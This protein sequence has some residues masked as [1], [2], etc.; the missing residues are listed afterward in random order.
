M[1]SYEYALLIIICLTIP[2]ILYIRIA[3]SFW[4]HQ[5]ICHTYDFIRPWSLPREGILLETAPTK[6]KFCD[7]Y[8]VKTR[9]YHDIT[10]L[11]KQTLVH[12][13]QANYI[14]SES[15]LHMISATTL[16]Q[17]MT[18]FMQSPAV[19]IYFD[20]DYTAAALSRDPAKDPLEQALEALQQ[21]RRTPRIQG[22]MLS[23]QIIL[24]DPAA[25]SRQTPLYYWNYICTKRT[26]AE[27]NKQTQQLIQTHDY[28]IRL[29]DN[30]GTL[31]KKEI[32]LCQGVVPLVQYRSYSYIIAPRFQLRPLSPFITIHQL[33]KSEIGTIITCLTTSKKRY[34]L[35]EIGNICAL[36]DN[37][38][39][40]V[41]SLKYR[42]EIYGMYFVKNANMHYDGIE[43]GDIGAHAGNA[44]QLVAS[45]K[46]VYSDELFVLG[47]EHVLHALLKIR[48]TYRVLLV[49][50]MA[51]NGVILGS[52]N[53][54][55]A[56]Q[57]N[58]AA[59]YLYNYAM[60]GMP[61]QANGWAIVV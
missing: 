56:F 52:L 23:T 51:D 40:F 57:S 34:I 13:L 4:S 58:V 61:F 16:D 50:E 59:Y 25:A 10:N 2:P 24:Y 33:H 9:K 28:N 5:P 43:G 29:F 17:Q 38:E 7:F 22:C 53:R 6:R 44:I 3:H 36:L 47:W 19:S 21:I 42:D 49:D 27:S 35:P 55:L 30:R 11:E 32:L 54:S 26:S 31:F 15:V 37:H 20:Y 14:S 41:F 12:F 8:H 48:N 45:V 46:Q 1:Q 39:L 18:G 60:Y